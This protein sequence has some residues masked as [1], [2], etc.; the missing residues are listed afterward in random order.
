LV[1][2]VADFGEGTDPKI[3]VD[4]PKV[5][6]AGAVVVAPKMD[7]EA[8]K[9]FVSTCSSSLELSSSAPGANPSSSMK[10]ASETFEGSPQTNPPAGG[11]AGGLVRGSTD[12]ISTGSSTA[13][14]F[15]SKIDETNDCG[16]GAG[17]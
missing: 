3:D 12:F 13:G 16:S 1:D 11:A 4:D 10:S 7:D 9:G 8:P 17:L 14:F 2:S 6:A 15:F 5:L